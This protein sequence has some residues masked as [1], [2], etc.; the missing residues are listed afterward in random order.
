MFVFKKNVSK[1]NNF[2]SGFKQIALNSN[3]E[4]RAI[5]YNLSNLYF[6]NKFLI[7]NPLI[8]AQ[9][10]TNPPIKTV[11]KMSIPTLPPTGK[12]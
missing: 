5:L 10:P 6:L 3:W 1:D 11:A 2:W 7:K 9:P 8:A 12:T 4:L